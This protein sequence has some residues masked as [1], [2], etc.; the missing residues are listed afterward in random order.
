VWLEL[1]LVVAARCCECTVS[2]VCVLFWASLLLHALTLTARLVFMDLTVSLCAAVLVLCCWVW[3][4]AVKLCDLQ[5]LP[6][7]LLLLLG[8]QTVTECLC[9]EA[10]QHTCIAAWHMQALPQKVRITQ[11]RHT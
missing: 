8:W 11:A 3:V 7:C 5:G 4:C 1:L 2:G 10:A 9:S 6:A